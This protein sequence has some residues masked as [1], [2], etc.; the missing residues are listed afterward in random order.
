MDR[1]M[2]DKVALYLP[3]V[4]SHARRRTGSK[5]GAELD[6]LIQEGL[7][8]VWKSLEKGHEPVESHVVNRMKNWVRYVHGKRSLERLW[9]D[10]LIY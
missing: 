6:D 7:I 4:T 9:D 1:A 2:S 5:Y 3:M 10:E 8:S